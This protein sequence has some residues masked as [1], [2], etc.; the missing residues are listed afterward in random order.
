MSVIIADAA[1]WLVLSGGQRAGQRAEPAMGNLLSVP[2][3]AEGHRI[4]AR[5]A[6]GEQAKESATAT[7]AVLL[8]MQLPSLTEPSCVALLLLIALLLAHLGDARSMVPMWIFLGCGIVLSG[9]FGIGVL[10]RAWRC[11][12]DCTDL[13]VVWYCTIIV[14]WIRRSVNP[15]PQPDPPCRVDRHVHAHRG[16]GPIPGGRS[17]GERGQLV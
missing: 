1:R 8:L 13:P 16:D 17:A 10:L 11:L 6:P 2:E 14:G 15:R 4:R 12:L 5:L 3:M 9:Y 7:E